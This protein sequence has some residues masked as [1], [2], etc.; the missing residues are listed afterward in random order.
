[1]QC[2]LCTPTRWILS[3]PFEVAFGFWV[4]SMILHGWSRI[5]QKPPFFRLFTSTDT[6]LSS[7]DMVAEIKFCKVLH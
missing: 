2:T 3:L 1:M 6:V 5:M 7:S 4:I